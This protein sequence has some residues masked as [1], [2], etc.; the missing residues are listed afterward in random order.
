MAS[1]WS[2][3]SQLQILFLLFL[4]GAYIPI[5]IEGIITGFTICLNPFGFFQQKFNG[6]YDFSTSYFDFG[7]ENNNLEKLGIKSDST[8]V[9][10]TSFFLSIIII[11]IMHLWIFLT[12]KLLS[13]E[14]KSTCW[15]KV[16]LK[17]HW[18]IQKLM[19]FFTF[20]LYIRI[21]LEMNQFILV[22]WVSEIYQ[23][24]FSEVKRIISTIITFLILIGWI[25]IIVITFLFTLS[26]DIDKFSES[27][28][29]RNKFAHLFEGM[30]PNKKSRLF[31]WLLQ[32]RRAV[33][34]I[35]LI[36]IEHKSSIIAISLWVGLQLIYIGFLVAIRP[37]KEV[38]CNV[39]ELTNELYFMVF[40]SSLLKYNTAADWEGTP[41]TAYT[42]LLSSN[43]FVVL[44]VIL[45]KQFLFFNKN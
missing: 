33:F 23:F 42:Y 34:V 26:K 27:P 4:T 38:N 18:I 10:M 36:T 12:Q 11:W 16:L 37:Y 2:V 6:D 24:N 17:I 9:N 31:V 29:K 5:D 41:T 39:I 40:L 13:K 21:I 30:S 44:L 22:S 20:A 35:L 15:N 8:I 25:A 28:K 43:P 7:L 45:S 14:S 3:I 19:I 32:I 1:L